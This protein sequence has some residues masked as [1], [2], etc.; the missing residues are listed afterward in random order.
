MIPTTTFRAV[1][2]RTTAAIVL[3]VAL[4]TAASLPALAVPADGAERPPGWSTVLADLWQ[5]FGSALGW[6]PAASSPDDGNLGP[7][8]DPDGLSASDGDGNLGPGMDPNGLSARDGDGNLGP[9]MD[10]NG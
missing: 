2:L 6:S 1:P 4:V 3:A 7:G 8:M 5:D 9:G 10:P